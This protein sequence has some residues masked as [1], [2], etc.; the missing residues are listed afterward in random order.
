MAFRSV[1]PTSLAHESDELSDFEYAAKCKQT[2][3]EH[4]LVEMEQVVPWSGLV[5]VDQ[6]ALP[7]GRWR[8]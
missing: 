1:N 3:R 6:A 2:C 4:F 5:S 8:S 7:K